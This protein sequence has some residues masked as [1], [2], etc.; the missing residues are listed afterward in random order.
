MKH[1]SYRSTRGRG[2]TSNR[3]SSS[4]SF[5]PHPFYPLL[6]SL[7]V[8]LSFFCLL[9]LCFS[10]SC[11]ISY[12][13]NSFSPCH[14]HSVSI[15]NASLQ[16][17]QATTNF[18][19]CTPGSSNVSFILLFISSSTFPTLNSHFHFFDH[20]P[21]HFSFT[22]GLQSH[23]HLLNQIALSPTVFKDLSMLPI[24]ILL[25]SN[26]SRYH[27]RACRFRNLILLSLLIL[28]GDVELNPGPFSASS[29]LNLVH[30]NTRSASSITDSFDKPA[31]IKELISDKF[32]D[33]LALTETWLSPDTPP[34]ILNSLT[35]KDYSIIHL[36]RAEGRGGGIAL[37][38]R[39]FLKVSKLSLPTFSSFEA[40]SVQFSVSNFSCSLLTVYRSP[41]L[42]KP[43][44]LSEFSSVLENLAP[45]SSELLITGDFN[46]HVDCSSDSTVT[47]FLSLLDTFDLTQ[48]VSFPT[49][50]SGHTLD[51]FI[52][53]NSSTF[54]SEI[55]SIISPF[56]DHYS[57][58]SILT[59]PSS[60]RTPRVTKFIRKVRSIDPVA[61][62]ADIL[63]SSLFSNPASTLELYAN[64][65]SSTLSVLLDKHAPLKS[66]TSSSRTRKPYITPEI[67]REKTKRSKLET[68]YRRYKT[69]INK[70]N[71][72]EQAK[73]VA[74]L[75]TVS[76]RSFY[77][78]LIAKNSN[79]PKKLWPV[80][81]SL[82]SRT[83]PPTFPTFSSASNLAESFLNFFQDK[84]TKLSSSFPPVS[85]S[86][87]H[88]PPF[89]P[90]SLQ[91]FLPTTITE[92]KQII[93]SSSNST[94]ELDSIPT[95]LLKSCIDTL[96]V[97]IT[98]L[99]N[100]SLSEGVFPSVFKT[101]VVKPLLKKHSL[102][103]ED[104]S[105]YRPISNLNFVSKVLERIIHTRL[106]NHLHSF[107]SV[108]S[109]QSAYRKF[110]STET[111]LLRIHNDLAL[112]INEQKVSALVLLDL[113]A[114]FDTI[115]HHILINRLFSTFGISES[116]LSLLSSYLLD[117]SQFVS[118]NS[119]SSSHSKLH[120]GVPQGS[121]LGPLLFTLYTTPLSYIFTDTSIKYHFYAD[122]TQLYISFSSTDSAS[123]L[124]LLS[125]TLDSI[126]VW[127]HNNR[128][129][130]NPS[131]TEYLL[132]GN[133]QQQRKI[134]S[135]SITFGGTL[136]SPTDSARNLGVIFDN[137]LSFNKQISS[138]CK[139]SF[140]HIR[141]LKQV[142]SSLDHKSTIILANS[143]VSSKLD[144]CNSLYYGLPSSSLSRLQ[145]V[146]N[147]LARLVVPSVRRTDHITPILKRLHWLP[148]EQRIKFKIAVLTFN[149]LSHK[150]PTYLS[151]L[152]V[153]YQP[154]RN[155]RSS[156]QHLLVVPNINP[157]LAEDPFRSL[158]LLSGT[159]FHFFA[160]MHFYFNFLHST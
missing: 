103:P 93:L 129:S 154:T 5:C 112:S 34:S 14:F 145:S 83:L 6:H 134:I 148:I 136:I 141:Q 9:Y 48:H 160:H 12:Q 76:K 104:L 158:L 52:T 128:L 114:A 102:P 3:R 1:C 66:V 126:Y 24:S 43:I 110:H 151:Q 15:F 27:H 108:C 121:V 10:V 111:A 142:R 97:P 89:S 71:F 79:N 68:V 38:Y 139:N 61:F 25:H 152:L 55:D 70:V 87:H 132:I 13:I 46:F 137:N 65:F 56:S 80:L 91:E 124:S 96:S 85:S 51:L 144:Y 119:I 2:S 150:Q 33:I 18:Q 44:F 133:P 23:S 59:V 75:I 58:H 17:T 95:T 122:D 49:H 106:T 101:A 11:H 28:S 82:L 41:S 159:L 90:L 100:L 92:V 155:L 156:D 45:S 74:K 135:S 50:S 98:T 116:A 8:L 127:L 138:V 20:Y 107:P 84:I 53:R 146:Q 143:L 40:L 105:S 36:P 22:I 62:S 69:E 73:K 4:R 113:S 67:L 77:R 131:K 109:F 37:I 54:I 47:Q 21:Y 118:I 86:V 94:C 115:D 140:Y 99:I 39:S 29:S 31:L 88:P 32:I 78:S 63:A 130:V 125:S 30:L 153:P 147:S 16:S 35:P 64:Q 123:S 26:K 72:R 120:T 149:T 19:P 60:T 81:N 57:I 7:D 157:T 117:R 42:S